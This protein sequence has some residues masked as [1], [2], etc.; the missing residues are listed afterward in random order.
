MRRTARRPA[1]APWI[2]PCSTTARR[3]L[4][5]CASPQAKGRL[6]RGVLQFCIT[7]ELRLAAGD[8]DSASSRVLRHFIKDYISRFARPPRD[9]P[10]AWRP[11]PEKSKADLL[12]HS[13]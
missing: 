1:P 8:V 4:H 3:H 11:A 9:D 2:R 5:R 10:K 13:Q 7:S 12:L 6:V